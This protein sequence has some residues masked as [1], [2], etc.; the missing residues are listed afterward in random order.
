[1]KFGQ[2]RSLVWGVVIAATTV[3]SSFADGQKIELGWTYIVPCT[4]GIFPPETANQRLIAYMNLE[5]PDIPSI[6]DIAQNCAMQGVA[7]AGLAAIIADPAAAMPAFYAGFN[8]CMSNAVYTNVGL[9]V[10]SKC[11]W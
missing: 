2:I 9:S 11:D 10:E 4:R 6:Q 8:S 3:S 1:M 5:A 7:A